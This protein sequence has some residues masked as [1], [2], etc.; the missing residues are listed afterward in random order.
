[1]S[2]WNLGARTRRTY[3]VHCAHCGLPAPAPCFCEG[4]E[5]GLAFCC[6]ACRQIYELS[7]ELT[8]AQSDV[9][10]RA[11]VKERLSVRAD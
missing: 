5:N 6:R 2:L 3:P 7:L 4:H 9:N 11:D 10:E 8:A 1:M